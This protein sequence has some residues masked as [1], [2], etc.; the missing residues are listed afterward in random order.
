MFFWYKLARAI[1]RTTRIPPTPYVTRVRHSSFACL[2]D[3]RSTYTLLA[4]TS[5]IVSVR[6]FV[7]IENAF[8]VCFSHGS[9]GTPLD[10]LYLALASVA[11][12]LLALFQRTLLDTLQLLHSRQ[13]YGFLHLS[14]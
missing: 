8:G 2:D 13:A 5:L 1:D 4:L 10:T 9:L 11:N 14:F 12:A 7:L 6:R 3:S